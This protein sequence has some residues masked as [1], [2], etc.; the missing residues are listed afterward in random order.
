PEWNSFQPQLTETVK[1]TRQTTQLPL[2]GAANVKSGDLLLLVGD[3]RINDNTSERW[4]V[5][6]IETVKVDP[7]G[8]FTTVTW[9]EPLGDLIA[10]N[11]VRPT[12][13]NPRAYVLR[14]RAGVFGG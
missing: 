11:E 5:R 13:Q 14:T 7:S 9:S 6:R 1:L 2:E 12:E 4:D 10:G 8:E 3:E